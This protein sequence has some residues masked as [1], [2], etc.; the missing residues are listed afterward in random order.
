[1]ENLTALETCDD[2]SLWGVMGE[3]VAPDVQRAP[4]A[5]LERRQSA[6]LMDAE[7]EQLALRSTT[8][9]SST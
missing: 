4:S 8:S 7:R 1:M 9:L 2:A 5:L 3:T 6:S